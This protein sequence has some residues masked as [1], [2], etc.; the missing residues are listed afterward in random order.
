VLT[1][2]NPHC[3]IPGKA[4]TLCNGLRMMLYV[5]GIPGVPATIASV[6]PPGNYGR[7]FYSCSLPKVR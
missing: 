1:L 4:E 6:H 5:Y 3:G 2:R 7:L